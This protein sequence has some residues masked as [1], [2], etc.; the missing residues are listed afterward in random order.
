[1]KHAAVSVRAQ[2]IPSSPIRKLHAFA[3]KA[4]HEGKIV[5]RLNIGQ[6]DLPTPKIFFRELKRAMR[7]TVAYAPS[8]GF[9]D[10]IDAWKRYYKSAGVIFDS[11]EIIVTTGGSEA[12]QFAM[13]AAADVGDE[14]IVFEPLYPNYISFAVE[15]GI[16]LVPITLDAEHHYHPPPQKAIEDKVTMRT[17]AILLC[18]PANPTG[19]VFTM[20]ELRAIAS[21]AQR[22]NLFIIADETYREIV[23][24]KNKHISM[25]SFPA[26][27]ERVILVDSVSK[28]F[29]V[30]GVRIGCLASK[31]KKIVEAALK[32]AQARLAAP[33][34][35]QL[36]VVPLLRSPRHYIRPILREYTKRRQLGSVLLSKFLGEKFAPPEGAYYSF[37]PLPVRDSEHFCR[38]LLEEFQDKNETIMLAPGR[39]FYASKGKGEDEVRLA[40]VLSL[41]RLKRAIELLRLALE[42]YR[43]IYK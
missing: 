31:N 8:A 43:S 17:R 42:R 2:Q 25:A 6:S 39:G 12:I 11:N 27:Q 3:V 19:T 37:F 35:E 30:C 33:T 20:A 36:A 38:W 10:V 40:F 18:N 32:L 28:R 16:K 4:G 21:I 26:L 14:M 1:M 9:S 34:L 22:H 24:G 29:N 41:P 13:L 15:A 5:Y 7:K 23:F